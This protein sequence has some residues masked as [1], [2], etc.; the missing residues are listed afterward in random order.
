VRGEGAGS[1]L[2]L[3]VLVARAGLAPGDLN[4]VERPAETHADLA[5]LIETGE[6]D[7]GLGLLAA[8]GRLGFIPLVTDESF[9]LVLAPPRLLRAAGAG[10]PGVHPDRGLRPPGGASR[11]LRGVVAHL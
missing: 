2:L 7:C 9:D 11:R 6:A 4:V 10:A 1:Q 5:A 8:A 3:E